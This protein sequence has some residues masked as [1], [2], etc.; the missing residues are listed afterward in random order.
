MATMHLLTCT[1]ACQEAAAAQCNSWQCDVVQLN[2]GMLVLNL[3]VP[4]LPLP[5][6][7]ILT[8]VLL[9]NR[10][11]KHTIGWANIAIT[12]GIGVAFIILG[13]LR[14]FGA[15][16]GIFL[17]LWA[18]FHAFRLW[19]CAPTPT[20]RTV[21][22][23]AKLRR[24]ATCAPYDAEQFHPRSE[25]RRLVMCLA[26]TDTM[27]ARSSQGDCGSWHTWCSQ[28]LSQSGWS[29]CR[30]VKADQF[31]DH[32]LYCPPRNEA[33]FQGKVSVAGGGRMDQQMAYV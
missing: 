16:G 33:L 21:L 25:L 31:E 17:G 26:S 1:F 18:I 14:L 3:L 11:N 15:L 29:S 2:V 8:D 27:S 24:S 6:A 32:P 10:V 9:L 13:A 12:G 4:A 28:R 7:F 30:Y 23:A 5:G 20:A 22:D 19:Q